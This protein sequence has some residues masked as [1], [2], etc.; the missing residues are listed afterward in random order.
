MTLLEFLKLMILNILNTNDDI[1]ADTAAR[2]EKKYGYFFLLKKYNHASMIKVVAKDALTCITSCIQNNETKYSKDIILQVL[3]FKKIEFFIR[4]EK[5]EIKNIIYSN[6]NPK[7][8]RL[9]VEYENNGSWLI[10][11][12]KSKLG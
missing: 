8:L 9:I 1:C 2:P 5:L 10:N 11:P 6:L 12:M 3:S 4:T 7:F